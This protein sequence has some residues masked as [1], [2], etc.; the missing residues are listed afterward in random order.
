MLIILLTKLIKV[1]QKRYYYYNRFLLERYLYN[2]NFSK[3]K[4]IKRIKDFYRDTSHFINFKSENMV[5]K[6]Y[7]KKN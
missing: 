6:E 1:Y 7:F 4:N 5:L 3:I 2:I